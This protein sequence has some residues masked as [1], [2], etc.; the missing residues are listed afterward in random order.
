MIPL[1]AA[2][3]MA[4]LDG[5]LNQDLNAETL[6]RALSHHPIIEFDSIMG[7]R[8]KPWRD[9]VNHAVR[10]RYWE[11]QAYQRP[12]LGSSAHMLHVTG[13]YD[14][15]LS[16]ALEN[17]AALSRRASAAI[18]T[19]RLL[20]GPWLHTTIGRRHIG[21]T[22]FGAAAEIDINRLQLRWFDACATGKW[23]DISP[24]QLFVMGRNEWIYENEWPIART[25]YVSYFLHSGGQAN[26]RNGDGTLSTLPPAHEP[27][28]QFRYDPAYPVPYGAGFDWKQVGGPDDC[29]TLELRDDILVFTSATF[30]EPTLIC[31]PLQVRL[32]AA[33][34]ARDTDWMA[35]IL[36]VY[37]D[38]KAIRLND[39][40][41][42]ARFRE[43]HD[44]EI[45]LP[46]GTIAEFA[47]DCWATC[48]ELQPGHRL[49]LEITSSAFGKY[50]INL[51]GGGA[52]GQERE[53][54][55]AQQTVYHD[56]VHP[57]RVILPIVRGR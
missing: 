57:S 2:G 14:D 46:C 49:R 33:T 41:V 54:V 36:D 11:E 1:A 30:D 13:W 43:G 22:D 12:L 25:E 31:G 20:V 7:R 5:H 18:S 37:P 35:K 53:P 47:I 19:Q 27:A 56:I 39:G 52:I 55:I 48:I 15:C 3:W 23:D 29:T 9:W 24:V 26:T 32:F 4:T 8:L 44:R 10:D 17:F 38:G 51:N 6:E 45:F 16:G 34:N 21:E 40:A 50:D 28:D 42:R